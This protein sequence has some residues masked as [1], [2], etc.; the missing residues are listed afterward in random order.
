MTLSALFSMTTKSLAIKFAAATALAASL[1]PNNSLAFVNVESSY[2]SGGIET[3]SKMSVLPD[4]KHM[5]GFPISAVHDKIRE[6]CGEPTSVTNTKKVATL[7]SSSRPSEY[8]RTVTEKP[9][10]DNDCLTWFVECQYNTYINTDATDDLCPSCDK[11]NGKVELLSLDEYEA[12]VLAL[13]KRCKE[14][15]VVLFAKPIRFALVR[16]HIIQTDVTHKTNPARNYSKTSREISVERV[17]RSESDFYANEYYDELLRRRS[18][19]AE[20]ASRFEKR[21]Q[22][23]L[24]QRELKAEQETQQTP[25][26]TPM[27]TQPADTSEGK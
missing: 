12:K 15:L 5:F 20:W 27:P 23:I 7:P 9:L 3:D 18:R 21:R 25:P 2:T 26:A 14:C 4:L 1:I 22:A 6:F 24:R 17:V 10:S 13:R 19:G 11:L 16:T 8:T